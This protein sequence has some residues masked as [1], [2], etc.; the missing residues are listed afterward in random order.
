MKNFFEV[1]FKRN[2]RSRNYSKSDTSV[3]NKSQEVPV[4]FHVSDLPGTR[5][6]KK[7]QQKWRKNYE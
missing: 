6:R 3:Q 4:P 7:N 1:I 5:I 2:I